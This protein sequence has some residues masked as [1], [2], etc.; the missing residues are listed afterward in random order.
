VRSFWEKRKKEE[1]EK[2]QG[3]GADAEWEKGA[4]IRMI[5]EKSYG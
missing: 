1:G 4:S 5:C 2:S 3:F